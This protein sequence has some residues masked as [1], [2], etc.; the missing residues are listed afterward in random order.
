[1]TGQ[2]EEVNENFRF[3]AETFLK[4]AQGMKGYRETVSSDVDNACLALKES[5]E[6]ASR[7]V[8][9]M[10]GV[11]VKMEERHEQT[12]KLTLDR[13]TKVEEAQQVTSN[14][15]IRMVG[16]IEGMVKCVDA[17]ILES[18]EDKKHYYDQYEKT[19]DKIDK[20]N[21]R[22]IVVEAKSEVRWGQMGAIGVAALAVVGGITLLLF[23]GLGGK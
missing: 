13:M 19:H 1:M 17:A 11:M 10:M 5:G 12:S 20:I 22:L 15:L 8:E 4:T 7:M 2:T 9:K 21:D 23:K 16:Q 18:K 3:A 14:A 6:N